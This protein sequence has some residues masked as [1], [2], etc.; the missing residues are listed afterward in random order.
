MCAAAAAGGGG[1]GGGDGDGIVA[2]GGHPFIY[3]TY[4]PLRPLAGS[5][6]PCPLAP[7]WL[8]TLIS[9]LFS[10]VNPPITFK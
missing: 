5:F 10:A 4:V 7:R 1:G 3:P 8:S 6:I 2:T 9:C